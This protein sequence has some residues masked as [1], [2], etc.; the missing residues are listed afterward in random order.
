[1]ELRSNRNVLC[2]YQGNILVRSKG[3]IVSISGN[4]NKRGKSSEYYY[5]VLLDGL[6][7]KSAFEETVVYESNL[8][9]NEAGRAFTSETVTSGYLLCI[10]SEFPDVNKD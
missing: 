2:F 1:M 10:D 3:L 8:H 6:K 4:D 7:E 5:S 9:H